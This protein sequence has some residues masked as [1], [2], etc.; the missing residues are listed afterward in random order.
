MTN[1]K[2][3]GDNALMKG[4]IMMSRDVKEAM[5]IEDESDQEMKQAQAKLKQNAESCDTE[6]SYVINDKVR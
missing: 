2:F 1:V 6:A 3:Y 5:R 4:E